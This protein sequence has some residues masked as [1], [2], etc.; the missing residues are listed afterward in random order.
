M[1]RALEN[2]LRA[3]V[4]SDPEGDL[5][6]QQR[7]WVMYGLLGMMSREKLEAVWEFSASISDENKRSYLLHQLVKKFPAPDFRLAK[8][9]AESI[10]VHYWRYSSFIDIASQMLKFGKSIT[11]S[12]G[13]L[14]N[15]ALA[16]ISEAEDN[17]ASVA[18][19][20][21]SSIVWEAGLA[22]AD[23]GELDW[24]ERLSDTDTYCPEHT[25]V[26]LRVAR[27]RAQQ[28]EREHAL[29]IA[30][31]V[32]EL[33][34]TISCENGVNLDLTNRAFDAF[35]VAVMV[36]EL[37]NIAESKVHLNNALQ[38]AIQSECSGDIDAHK[39]IRAIALKLANEGNIPA[40]RDAAA[41]IRL[42]VRRERVM[43]EISDGAEKAG[44][45]SFIVREEKKAPEG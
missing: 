2:L 34:E 43:G 27:A 19:D 16:I 41:R 20:D 32:G 28:G 23:A 11:T 26:L 42:A 8:R 1:D 44:E 31:K 10:P 29:G 36:A 12:S 15:H 25:E 33:A 22:L 14:R 38:L 3:L 7:E 21:R 9:V 5:N 39:C 18:E 40:A 17:I 24:A 45:T 4:G 37:G 35:D 13:E 6:D 30:R